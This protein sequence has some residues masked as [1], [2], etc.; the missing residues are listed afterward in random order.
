MRSGPALRH[1]ESHRSIHDATYHE[2]RQMT[3]ILEKIHATGDHQRTLEVA[4]T[5]LEQWESR[6]LQHAD[7]EEQA[8]YAEA[9]ETDP[10][11]QELI[12]KLKRDHEILRHLVYEIK[13]RLH[14]TQKLTDDIM[15]RFQALLPVV[16][17]HS[18]QEEE[19]LVGTVWRDNLNHGR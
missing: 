18:R 13:K 1:V 10:G 16:E 19:Y 4:H 15:L 2:A 7:A 17:F 3:E 12:T 9:V 5:L 6:T 8:L 11:I 14:K